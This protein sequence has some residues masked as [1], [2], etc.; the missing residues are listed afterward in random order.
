MPVQ[1]RAD[2]L[3]QCMCGTKN[4]QKYPVASTLF[5][6]GYGFAV[7]AEILMHFGI[8]YWTYNRKA[9]NL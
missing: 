8:V 3:I 9:L 7:V 4:P 6:T 1:D 2:A 5:L